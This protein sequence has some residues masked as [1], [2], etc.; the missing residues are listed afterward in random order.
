MDQKKQNQAYD[1]SL[2]EEN[3]DMQMSSAEK[4]LRKKKK[5]GKI[6]S[7][8]QGSSSKAHKRKR[9]PVVIFFV[10]LLTV[11]L[12]SV[13]ILF[14]HFNAELNEINEDIVE[15]NKKLT[16]LQNLQAKYQ[17]EIDS[18]LTDSYVR[19]YAETK[20]N[21]TPAK[22]VQKKFFSLSNGDKGE[23]VEEDSSGNIFT[24]VLDAFSSAFM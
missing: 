19:N 12:A 10:S 7:I 15:K 4:K 17:L 23:V 11:V 22:N 14:V 8:S 2:F 21:M 18:K 5:S 13:A 6:I 1:L 9:N 3:N 24:V 16:E 20:L